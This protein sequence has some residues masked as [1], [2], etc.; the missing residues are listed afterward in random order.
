MAIDT[1]REAIRELRG[2]VPHVRNQKWKARIYE[3]LN[4]LNAE[5]AR[6]EKGLT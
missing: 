3:V 6:I 4:H 1:I 5:K 2:I